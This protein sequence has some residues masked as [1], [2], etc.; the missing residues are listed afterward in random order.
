[1]KLRVADIINDSIVDGPGLRLT[2][3]VQGCTH[4]CKGCHNP[5]T[6]DINGGRLVDIDKIIEMIKE[7]PLLDG[8]TLSGG[9]PFLQTEPLEEFTRK[10][11]NMGLNVI[12]YTGF[13]WEKLMINKE[14]YIRLLQNIDFIID[15]PFVLELKSYELAFKGS[16]NQRTIDVSR[17]L[18]E[19]KIIEHIF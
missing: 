7:N 6:H 5:Q 2:V 3:F 14:K 15:G 9:E 11:K 4:N 18:L 19:N 12:A 17:S 10:V 13:T 16:S 1:M 8:V